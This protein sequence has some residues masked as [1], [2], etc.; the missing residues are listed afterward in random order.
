MG[1]ASGSGR[2]DPEMTFLAMGA[3]DDF[4]DR[5]LHISPI[6]CGIFC[7]TLLSNPFTNKLILV[8]ICLGP[9]STYI[10]GICNK[11]LPSLDSVSHLSNRDVSKLVSTLI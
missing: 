9:I 2:M 5:G 3:L 8:D 1:Q 6:K 10:R 4:N 7:N 11:S